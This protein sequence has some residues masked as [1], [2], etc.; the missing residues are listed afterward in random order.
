MGGGEERLLEN[1]AHVLLLL[2]STVPGGGLR[3]DA[4]ENGR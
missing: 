4:T 2:R 3:L 1:E